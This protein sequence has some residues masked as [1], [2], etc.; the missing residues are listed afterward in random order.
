[1]TTMHT[2]MYS[3]S[4]S[5]GRWRTLHLAAQVTATSPSQRVTVLDAL[6]SWM[7]LNDS[8]EVLRYA[9]TCQGKLHAMQKISVYKIYYFRCSVF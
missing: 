8:S 6:T 9:D 7:A 5:S 2:H 1:M 3:L 4:I